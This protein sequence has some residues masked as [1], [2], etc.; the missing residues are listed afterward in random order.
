MVRV[1]RRHLEK[2]IFEPFFTTK[3][4]ELAQDLGFQ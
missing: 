1:F 3:E 2:K 4:W